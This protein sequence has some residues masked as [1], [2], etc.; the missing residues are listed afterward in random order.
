MQTKNV[1]LNGANLVNFS[2]KTLQIFLAW[3]WNDKIGAQFDDIFPY[4]YLG[5]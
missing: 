5:I 3:L 2:G 1:I 4:L